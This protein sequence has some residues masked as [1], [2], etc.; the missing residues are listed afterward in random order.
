MTMKVLIIGGG[1][2]EHAIAW[3]LAQSSQLGQLIA[4]PLN[5]GLADLAEPA[6]MLSGTSPEEIARYADRA[7][8]DLTI[9]GPEAMLC[10]GIADLFEERGLRIFGPNRKAAR[11]EGSKV[12]AKEFLKKYRIPAARDT[13]FDDYTAALN[14]VMEQ[15]YPVVVKADG[16]AAGKGVTVARTP[17]EARDALKA[18]LVDKVFGAAGQRVVVEEC[19][20]GQEA[21]LLAL[22]DG[23]HL[24]PLLAAQDHKPLLDADQG[25]NTGGMGAI[26]PTPLVTEAI[27]QQ[28]L[29]EILQPVLRGFL[30]EGI[31]YT[32]IL[33]AGLMMTAGGPKVLEFNCRFGDPEAQA[34]LPLLDTDL[35]NLMLSTLDGTL[36]RGHVD[37]RDGKTCVSVVMASGGYPGKYEKQIPIKGLHAFD[38]KDRDLMVFHAGTQRIGRDI[39]TSGGR[40]LNVTAIGDSPEDARKRAYEAV[41]KIHF[42]GAQYRKDIGSKALA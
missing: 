27:R 28:V 35:L 37:W 22:T 15:N 10:A 8:I 41:D 42:D 21:S 24:L 7:G 29:D 3:K 1:G 23:E 11:I 2:R 5:G 9:V 16:L 12:W 25:P 20:V 17:R 34:V 31:K 14:Y 40:V 33:Y 6:E 4:H 32:G 30:A 39:V 18:I 19:L 36:H 26:C 38:P 13:V